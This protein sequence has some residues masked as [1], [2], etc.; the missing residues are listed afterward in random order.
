MEGMATG[1]PEGMLTDGTTMG[2]TEGM[3]ADG[4]REGMTMGGTVGLTDSMM[5]TKLG[6]AA[7]MVRSGS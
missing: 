3:L 6:G 1:A 2:A 4:T 7:A 5:V